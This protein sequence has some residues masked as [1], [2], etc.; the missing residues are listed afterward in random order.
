MSLG[1]PEQFGGRDL[2]QP[3]DVAEQNAVDDSQCEDAL[4]SWENEGGTVLPPTD[5]P[6]EVKPMGERGERQAGGDRMSND[7]RILFGDLFFS[8]DNVVLAHGIVPLNEIIL[9]GPAERRSF[10]SLKRKTWGE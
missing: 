2:A 3:P 5:G 7:L 9:D 6:P 4:D 1:V 10:P 8:T